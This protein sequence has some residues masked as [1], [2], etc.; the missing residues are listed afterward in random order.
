MTNN[1]LSHI[2]MLVIGIS[3]SFWIAWM[4]H[5]SQV[6][7]AKENFHHIAEKDV[8]LI[9]NEI[10]GHE[11]ILYGLGGLYLASEYISHAEFK[12]FTEVSTVETN[13]YDA[14]GWIEYNARDHSYS[15]TH[16]FPEEQSAYEGAKITSNNQMYKMIESAVNNRETSRFLRNL[17]Q[18]QLNDVHHRVNGNDQFHLIILNPVF[19]NPRTK[20]DLI[21]LSYSIIDF[22]ILSDSTLAHAAAKDYA[23]HVVYKL[24]SGQPDILIY[25]TPPKNISPYDYTVTTDLSDTVIRWVAY[26]TPLFYKKYGA[27]NLYLIFVV[28]CAFAM[29]IIFLRQMLLSIKVLDSARHKAEEANRLKSNFLATMSHEIRT[30]MN[31]IQGM[32]E[33][34]LSSNNETQIKSHAETIISSGEVLMHVIDDILDFSKIEAGRM[35]L[36]PIAIDMLDLADDVAELYAPKAREKAVELVVRY[37]PGSERFVY[38]DPVRMRQ[39]LSNLV[40]NAIKFTD[41]GHISVTIEEDKHFE[42]EDGQ[43]ALNFK[44]S[45]T[46]IGLSAGAQEKIFEKF[47]QADNTTTRKYGG[48]GLGLSICKRLIEM[49]GGEIALQ[50]REGYGSTFYFTLP[51]TRNETTGLST[52][53]PPVLKDMRVL[54]VDD[55][56][57]IRQLVSEQLSMAA[58]RCD[59]AESGEIALEKMQDAYIDND[60]YSLVIIDYLMPDMNG[61]TLAALIKDYDD[62]K[63]ACLVML[64]AAGSPSKDDYFAGKGFS[65]YL[66]K[67]VRAH[68]LIETLALVWEVFSN[69]NR[70]EMIHVDPHALGKKYEEENKYKLPG[71]HILIAEDNLVNQTFIRKTLEEMDAD[72]TIVS[73]GRE[74]LDAIEQTDFDLVIMDCLMPVMDGFEASREITRRKNNGEILGKLPIVAL[75]ANAMK[76]DRERCLEAGM[77]MYLTKP[78]RK[79]ALKEA[80]FTILR[81]DKNNASKPAKIVPLHNTQNDDNLILCEATLMEAK[82]VL[83]DEYEQVLE[84]YISGS[85]ERINEIKSALSE[86]NIE[87]VI[88]P[89]H[90]LKSTSQQMGAYRLFR[91]AKEMEYTAKAIREGV[92][93]NGENIHDL[94]ALL[95]DIEIQF[96]ETQDALNA[97]ENYKPRRNIP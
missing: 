35:D 39:I 65:A 95:Y 89:A 60:P 45:D 54:I 34:I 92:C 25:G 71:A 20:E 28:L 26:P 2:A 88:R 27:N 72:F 38:A 81:G 53:R 11:N 75:T 21:G 68:A 87:A 85:A 19:K 82:D 97:L 5:A 93:E 69:G 31:G 76:G 96:A 62:F 50:S 23:D 47:S 58:M 44:V 67:P 16:I 18:M 79:H 17:D 51:F 32:A 55:L 41:T 48:T 56:A 9:K 94:F 70:H 46:G 57:V 36:D 30:P 15:Y 49:M 80:L 8:R 64:T 73:N 77:E 40:N 90:T 86:K 14:F 83:K 12:L 13:S 29:T 74:A 33:L 6:Q 91:T 66:S 10:K 42:C 78:V 4:V 1:W 24:E 37:V 59:T 3:V 43:I 7:R 22:Y 63:D 52:P 84:L 61:E